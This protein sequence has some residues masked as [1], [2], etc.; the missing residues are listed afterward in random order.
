MK[1]R[2]GF[3][4]VFLLCFSGQAFGQ[5][6]IRTLKKKKMQYEE[7]SFE[8]MIRRY[9]G[10]EIGP[11]NELEGIYSV[12]CVIIK[13]SQNFLTGHENKRIVARKDNYA[14]VAIMK[15]WPG[16]KREFIEVS[17]SYREANRYPVVGEFSS[18]VDGGG[19]LYKH[20]EPDGNTLPFSMLV[21]HD[22][23]IEGEYAYMKGRKTITY[24]LSYLKIFPRENEIIVDK[25]PN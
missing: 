4:L 3:L 18:I 16:S 8:D 9:F 19:L 5:G 13:T 6:I 15:D 2:A 1:T 14:R 24:K 12:S 7:V 20:I 22:D 17:L 21:D 23:L 11:F 10:K 25:F